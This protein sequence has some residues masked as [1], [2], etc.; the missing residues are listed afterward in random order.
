MAP[1][2]ISAYSATVSG[3]I[4]SARYSVVSLL[5][6]LPTRRVPSVGPF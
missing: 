5:A 4:K 1:C 2:I 3:F 6:M